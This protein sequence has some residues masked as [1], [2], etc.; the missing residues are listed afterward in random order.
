LAQVGALV[1]DT[2]EAPL[3]Q[4]RASLIQQLTTQT[5][6]RLPLNETKSSNDPA[7]VTPIPK[8]SSTSKGS[9]PSALLSTRVPQPFFP[10]RLPT[11]V[12]PSTMITNTNNIGK[13]GNGSSSPRSGDGTLSDWICLHQRLGD[14]CVGL[15]EHT[16]GC[17]T[18]VETLEDAANLKPHH[19]PGC[20]VK[21]SCRSGSVIMDGSSMLDYYMTTPSNGVTSSQPK[22]NELIHETK[23]AASL[24]ASVSRND[25]RVRP[26]RR[27]ATAAISAP[28]TVSPLSSIVLA[29]NETALSMLNCER[30]CP[31]THRVSHG[32]GMI[33]E[34]DATWLALCQFVHSWRAIPPTHYNLVAQHYWIVDHAIQPITPPNTPGR[35]WD[36]AEFFRLQDEPHHHDKDDTVQDDNDNLSDNNDDSVDCYLGIGISTPMTYISRSGSVFCWHVEDCGLVSIN[37][38][39]RPHE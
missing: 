8:M 39:K 38:V 23:C 33:I 35:R 37:I 11:L 12:Q 29:D 13:S 19:V 5:K 15:E 3:C 24:S 20:R 32:D 9:P 4:S 21:C 10:E 25:W 22:S 14:G 26:R 16:G 18:L 34:N 36:I 27:A 28:R 1:I 6:D 7:N 30:K 2:E 17:D 31:H